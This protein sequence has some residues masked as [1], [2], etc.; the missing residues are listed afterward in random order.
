[1]ITDLIGLVIV[2]VIYIYQKRR[3]AASVV[4]VAKTA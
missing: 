3:H 2:S 4:F 1:L